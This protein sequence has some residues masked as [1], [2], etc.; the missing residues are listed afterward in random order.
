MKKL[1]HTKI[2]NIPFYGID[3]NGRATIQTLLQ[4][5]QELAWEHANILDLGMEKLLEQNLIWV[6]ARQKIKINEFPMWQEDVQVKTWATGTDRLFWY[7]DFIITNN[8]GKEL[9]RASSSWIIMNIETRR[10]FKANDSMTIKIE[11][12]DYAFDYK[13]GKISTIKNRDK[14]FEKRISYS[15]LDLNDHVNNIKY[16]EW[17]LDSYNL[18]YFKENTIES[19]EMNYIAEAKYGDNIFTS[20]EKN[21]N[22]HFHTVIRQ[23]DEK[24]LFRA[25]ISWEEN[26]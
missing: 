23:D 18:E 24:E 14:I 25:K 6:L 8:V 9:A 12:P 2:F 4:Y 26:S 21:S 11:N 16:L 15:D 7:R 20:I 10:P 13:L 22:E 3:F 19:V 17:I 1:S 5:L